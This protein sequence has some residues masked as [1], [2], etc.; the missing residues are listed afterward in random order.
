MPAEGEAV[1]EWLLAN[2]E[3]WRLPNISELIEAA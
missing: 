1:I 2:E 3:L